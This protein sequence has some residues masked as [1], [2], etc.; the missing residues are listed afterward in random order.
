MIFPRND[1]MMALW[2][3]LGYLALLNLY[4]VVPILISD[5]MLALVVLYVVVRAITR[6]RYD[7]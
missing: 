6:V 3:L 1:Q 2:L 5:V 7:A 4:P